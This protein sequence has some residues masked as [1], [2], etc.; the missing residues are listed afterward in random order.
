MPDTWE[1]PGRRRGTWPSIASRWRGGSGIRQVAARDA[2]ARM[3][4]APERAAPGL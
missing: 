1:F 4:H 3:V 2:D